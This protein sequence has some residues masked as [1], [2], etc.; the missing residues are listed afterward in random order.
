MFFVHMMRCFCP[1]QDAQSSRS[2]TLSLHEQQIDNS[3]WWHLNLSVR[4]IQSHEHLIFDIESKYHPKICRTI[5]IFSFSF[6]SRS[7]G[8]PKFWTSSFLYIAL[9]FL[10][11]HYERFSTWVP[12]IC[13]RWFFLHLLEVRTQVCFIGF[14]Q[15]QL[16]WAAWGSRT[17]QILSRRRSTSQMLQPQ[18]FRWENVAGGSQHRTSFCER[19]RSG[20]STSIN[21][22]LRNHDNSNLAHHPARTSYLPKIE[23]TY[24]IVAAFFGL[25]QQKV[26]SLLLSICDP[27]HH[28]KPSF[29]ENGSSIKLDLGAHGTLLRHFFGHQLALPSV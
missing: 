16:V 7:F 3:E 28:F 12:I 8:S 22:K 13:L 15:D 23:C 1:R 5:L 2:Q 29:V 10:G 9:S 18:C 27:W 19:G 26:Q 11:F 21:W 6:V 25:V 14:S 20:E 17:E 24:M 4:W